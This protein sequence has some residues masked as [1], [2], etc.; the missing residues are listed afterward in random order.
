MTRLTTRFRVDAYIARLRGQ[1]IPCFVVAHGD[2]M[3]GAVLVKLNT[4]DGRAICFH[5]IFDLNA[6]ARIWAILAKGPEAKVDHA[7]ARQS[8]FD[9][10]LWVLEVED[11]SGQHLPCADG[12]A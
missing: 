4:L 11:R 1:G 6:D 9:P 8:K 3:A 12:L 5:S 2:D 7:V 10:D